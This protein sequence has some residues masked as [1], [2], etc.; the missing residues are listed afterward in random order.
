MALEKKLRGGT[1]VETLFVKM[2]CLSVEWSM[3]S[4]LPK[5]FG[6][7]LFN[8]NRAETGTIYVRDVSVSS[9]KLFSRS[10][11]LPGNII[12][13]T[14]TGA[15]KCT[16][17]YDSFHRTWRTIHIPCTMLCWIVSWRNFASRHSFGAELAAILLC[18][19]Q[20]ATLSWVL[21]GRSEVLGYGQFYT[22][23]DGR[24]LSRKCWRWRRPSCIE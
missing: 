19:Y 12:G 7:I 1:K 22:T 23:K 5:Y 10:E 21:I 11:N 4:W 24:S 9:T 18:G 3:R 15:R 14:S 13:R 16:D 17:E 6:L 20:L 8:S 2:L